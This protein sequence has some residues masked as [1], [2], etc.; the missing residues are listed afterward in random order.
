MSKIPLKTALTAL[1]KVM[2]HD[3]YDTD[4]I[5]LLYQSMK[6]ANDI[7]FCDLKIKKE[8]TR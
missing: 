2:Y 5:Q 6:E 1:T 8:V 4:M 3:R 7:L